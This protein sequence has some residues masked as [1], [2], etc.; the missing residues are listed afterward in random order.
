MAACGAL[1]ARN[2]HVA[3]RPGQ[4]SVSVNTQSVKGYLYHPAAGQQSGLCQPVFLSNTARKPT[5]LQCVSGTLT[6]PDAPIPLADAGRH[7]VCFRTNKPARLSTAG[8]FEIARSERGL[9]RFVGQLS[10]IVPLVPFLLDFRCPAE[11]PDNNA[12]NDGQKQKFRHRC[13][14]IK[15]RPLRNSITADARST[16]TSPAVA[17]VRSFV[18]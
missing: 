6:T 7:E 12:T 9:A 13:S 16:T 2:L 18:K 10:V 8:L 14:F 4:Y 3:A 1:G 11:S 5:K 17:Q 15:S